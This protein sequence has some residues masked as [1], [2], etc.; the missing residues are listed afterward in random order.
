MVVSPSGR[1]TKHLADPALGLLSRRVSGRVRGLVI[2][3]ID[4]V[5]KL[6]AL[7]AVL[8]SRATRLAS[9]QPDGLAMRHEQTKLVHFNRINDTAGAHSRFLKTN[10]KVVVTSAPAFCQI[11]SISSH[12]SLL[13]TSAAGKTYTSGSSPQPLSKNQLD[14]YDLLRMNTL[15]RITNGNCMA[16]D[17]KTWTLSSPY[18]SVDCRP[19][20]QGNGRR[21][22]HTRMNTSQKARSSTHMGPI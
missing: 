8:L 21:L 11:P 19:G 15:Q 6:T 18:Q 22:T 12:H 9:R 2:K 5:T 10:Q 14:H 16:F 17:D 7:T 4:R 3:L 20:V 1:Q 13:T